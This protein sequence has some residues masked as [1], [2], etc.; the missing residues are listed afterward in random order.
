MGPQSPLGSAHAITCR[1]ITTRVQDLVAPAHPGPP[2][3]PVL[4]HVP[5]RGCVQGRGGLGSRIP[6][7]RPWGDTCRAVWD[8][9]TG[10]RPD[11]TCW[12][13]E[14]R[15]HRSSRDRSQRPGHKAQ[16][17]EWG[18]GQ[19]RTCSDS[20]EG[21]ASSAHYAQHWGSSQDM[22]LSPVG[23]V[24]PVVP[25][26]PVSRAQKYDKNPAT[27]QGAALVGEQNGPHTPGDPPSGHRGPRP[28]GGSL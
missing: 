25:D 1:D 28:Q 16:A 10:T 15:C 20:P 19:G 3:R 7:G 4:P 9:S 18:R 13:A 2:S 22:E 27:F 23:H 14:N 6:P 8:L 12:G 17:T 11:A 5:G 21:G 24:C 26:Q